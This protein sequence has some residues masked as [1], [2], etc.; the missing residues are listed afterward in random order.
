LEA[1]SP[2]ARLPIRRIRA[3]WKTTAPKESRA[4]SPMAPHVARVTNAPA[5]SASTQKTQTVERA[6]LAR[7]LAV[8][9]QAAA[10]RSALLALRAQRTCQVQARRANVSRPQSRRQ[11]SPARAR[12]V[13]RSSVT[14]GCPASPPSTATRAAQSAVLRR[15]QVAIASLHSIASMGLFAATVTS[16]AN[17]WPRVARVQV[18]AVHAQRASGAQTKSAPK[19]SASGPAPNAIPCIDAHAESASGAPRRRMDRATS[20]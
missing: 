8:I 7:R 15:A 1:R 3:E 18:S 9:V 19:S 14:K 17:L 6:R 16:V 10:Q 11:A 5:D 20:P 4:R 13:K 12:A 2:P